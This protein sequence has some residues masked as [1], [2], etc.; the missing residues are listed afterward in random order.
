MKARNKL[1]KL[2]PFMND[3]QKELV[4]V[5]STGVP[6]YRAMKQV[7]YVGNTVSSVRRGRFS[8]MC[9]GKKGQTVLEKIKEI[10]EEDYGEFTKKF[11][12]S[13]HRCAQILQGVAE[14]GK[15][16]LDRILAIREHHRIITGTNKQTAPVNVQAQNV[17]VLA[18]P[19]TVEDFNGSSADGG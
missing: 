9:G 19:V 2:I 7:G 15:R 6:L 1:K 3:K 11:G 17:L 18:K 12:L 13:G 5:C 4:K 14:G 16:D 10:F 8:E